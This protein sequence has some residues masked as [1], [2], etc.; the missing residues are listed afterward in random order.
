MAG[1]RPVQLWVPDTRQPSFAALCR[2]QSAK[3]AKD[4]HE[5]EILEWIEDISDQKGWR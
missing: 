5:T 4:P 3:L 1:L 2:E